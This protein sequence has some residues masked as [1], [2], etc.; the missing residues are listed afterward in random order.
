MEVIDYDKKI[1]TISCVGIV[2]K[3]ADE[4]LVIHFQTVKKKL[5]KYGIRVLID[6]KSAEILQEEGVDFE[7]MCMQSDFL[8]S[9][10]GDGTLISLCRR[11][12]KYNK[13]ILGI[14][15]GQLGFL[16]D[17]KTDKIEEFIDNIFLGRYR[18]DERM[19]L[20]I[21]L[22]KG[23][24]IKKV[25]AFND[26]VFARD[27]ASSMS[28]IEAYIDDK[29]IN[30]YHGDGLIVSTPTGST[31]YNISAGGPVVYP[32]TKAIILTPICPHS[33]TQRPLVLPVDFEIEFKSEDD[34]M[35][36]IDGQ[37]RYG[38]RDFEKIGVKIADKSARLIHSLERNYF[39]VLRDKLRWGSI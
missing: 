9:I 26:V 14:Y 30:S 25:V 32:L 6:E 16:T 23:D 36:V 3:P 39:D 17:I 15:A 34:V 37:D 12:F 1:D 27:N 4:S 11:S 21:S 10:G 33:L 8:I 7:R 18:V 2:T 29:L 19:L 38:M 31:A 28:L 22:K 24:E 35:V 20:E 5:L 13:P